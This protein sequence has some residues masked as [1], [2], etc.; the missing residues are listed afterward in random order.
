M[1]S[2][3]FTLEPSYG[4]KMNKKSLISG[5]KVEKELTLAVNNNGIKQMINFHEEK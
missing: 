3:S 1:I 5:M 4:F 2:V